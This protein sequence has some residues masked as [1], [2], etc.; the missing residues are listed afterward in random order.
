MMPRRRCIQ[1]GAEDLI[2]LVTRMQLL[3]PDN[4]RIDALVPE[5]APEMAY[6]PFDGSLPEAIEQLDTGRFLSLFLLSSELGAAVGSADLSAPGFPSKARQFWYA[7]VEQPVSQP[8]D[9]VSRLWGPDLLF[10]AI[11]EEDGLDVGEAD[12]IEADRF[13]WNHPWLIEAAVRGPDGGMVRRRG[14]A[15]AGSA[16]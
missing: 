1:L 15:A 7:R 2:P 16:D 4:S 14:P 9:V 6:R 12:T 10:V 13:P 3:V 5:D 8:S 11:S